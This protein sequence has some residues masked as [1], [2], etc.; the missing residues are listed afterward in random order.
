[1]EAGISS[2][3]EGSWRRGLGRGGYGQPLTPSITPTAFSPL[4]SPFACLQVICGLHA[5]LRQPRI[6][7][8]LPRLRGVAVEHKQRRGA[9]R[10]QVSGEAARLPLAL[11]GV[12]RPRGE[13]STP[14]QG[15]LGFL[16]MLF[17]LSAEIAEYA[18]WRLTPRSPRAVS[19]LLAQ[20]Q[21]LR[22]TPFVRL[23]HLEN[24]AIDG[25]I[26]CQDF[27]S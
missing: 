27:L 11:C 5:A 9:S 6:L 21:A 3:Q 4:H 17:C 18:P 22:S 12:A 8:Q 20:L 13:G 10:L 26:V 25:C 7:Q 19:E 2:A 15:Q 23:F 24:K 14:G 1:M 16:M